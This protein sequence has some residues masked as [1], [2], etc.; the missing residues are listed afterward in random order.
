MLGYFFFTRRNTE[1]LKD[2]HWG[3]RR[4]RALRGPLLANRKFDKQSRPIKRSSIVKIL[5]SQPTLIA[6]IS[7]S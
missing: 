3:R 4:Y 1:V 2:N 5:S 6:I 7:F